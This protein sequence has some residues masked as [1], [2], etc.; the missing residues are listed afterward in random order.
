MRSATA[1]PSSATTTST[2]L[3]TRTSLTLPPF[4]T[5]HRSRQAIK[6]CRPTSVRMCGIVRERVSKHHTHHYADEAEGSTERLLLVHYVHHILLYSLA[7]ILCSRESRQPNDGSSLEGRVR[8]QG[9][10][11]ITC[12]EKHGRGS[13]HRN[14]RHHF[15]QIER[16]D[17]RRST[18]AAAEQE[19]PTWTFAFALCGRTNSSSAKSPRHQRRYPR[20]SRT[21]IHTEI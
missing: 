13:M 16:M 11:G 17:A 1:L 10:F 19:T 15:Q 14:A 6:A 7:S 4:P 12:D 3:C 21:W 2:C 20:T 18:P 8:R 9:N 5:F